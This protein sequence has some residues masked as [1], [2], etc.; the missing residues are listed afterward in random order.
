MSCASSS[1]AIFCFC[2]RALFADFVVAG[3]LYGREAEVTFD[4]F[5]KLF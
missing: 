4:L 3:E 5:P 2:F 1:P